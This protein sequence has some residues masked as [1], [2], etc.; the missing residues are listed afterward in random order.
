MD[1]VQKCG[2]YLNIIIIII[3]III[4]ELQMGCLPGGGVNTI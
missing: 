4:T 1:N 2:S 3:I